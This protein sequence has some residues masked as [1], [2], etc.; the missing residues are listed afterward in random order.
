MARS[1]VL[2][3]LTGS[4]KSRAQLEQKLADRNV[5][6]DAA[7][8]V[9]DRYEDLGL[10]DDV[11]FARMWVSSRV[12]YRHLGRS[13]LRRELT[14]KGVDRDTVADALANV[15]DEQEYEGALALVRRKVTAADRRELASPDADRQRLVRRLV[16]MLARKGYPPGTAFRAV[17]E[18]LGED[19]D[20]VIPDDD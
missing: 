13:A 20:G 5:P 19:E 15:S 10:V 8:A 6:E 12:E 11:E 16:S 14:L 3:Q 18:V 1:I 7:T 9:L 4:A 17:N 2:R